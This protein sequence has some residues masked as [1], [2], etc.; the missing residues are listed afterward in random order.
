MLRCP[1]PITYNVL[2]MV[3]CII[4]IYIYIYI[5]IERDIMHINKSLSIY[6][7]IYI[8]TR[9]ARDAT[10]PPP[11]LARRATLLSGRPDKT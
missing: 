11:P 9:Q 6:I 10:L 8:Y 4:Y 7:Y 1:S 2:N 3:I 5:Y